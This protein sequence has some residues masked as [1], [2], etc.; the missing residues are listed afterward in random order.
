VTESIYV[1]YS[2]LKDV[3]QLVKKEGDVAL[4]SCRVIGRA[5]ARE[6]QDYFVSFLKRNKYD[7]LSSGGQSQFT[8]KDKGPE[9]EKITG[10]V[11][12]WLSTPLGARVTECETWGGIQQFW[13][14]MRAQD[15]EVV[16]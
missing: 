4:V 10:V 13:E 11:R 3:P 15:F 2:Y 7:S 9:G 16:R 6:S 12:F 5:G 14:N 1:R 8:A